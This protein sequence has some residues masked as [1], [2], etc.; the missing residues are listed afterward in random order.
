MNSNVKIYNLLH[1]PAMIKVLK[2]AAFNSEKW[3]CSDVSISITLYEL[4]SLVFSIRTH[5]LQMEVNGKKSIVL[6]CLTS[7][8]LTVSYQCVYNRTFL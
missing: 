7:I 3:S 4:V 5:L 6:R 2:F 8:T 1:F